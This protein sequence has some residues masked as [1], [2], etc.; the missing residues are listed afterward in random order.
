MKA[1]F[2]LILITCFVSCKYNKDLGR[3]VDSRDTTCIKELAKAEDDFAVNKLTYCHYIG[4]IIR[5]ELRSQKEMT[6]LLKKYNIDFTNK[7]SSCIVYEDQ[8]EYCYC[9]FMESKIKKRFGEKFIDS[10]LVEADELY[11]KNNIDSTFYYA[12]C[13]SRPMYP[14]DKDSSPDEQSDV[15]QKEIDAVL[16]YPVGYVKRP[17]YDVSAFTNVSFDVDKQGNAKITSFGFI[18][19][20]KANEK[21]IPYLEKEITSIIKKNEWQPATIRG[22]KVKS[23]MVL[24][25]YLK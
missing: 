14:G 19:D 3:N 24:R 13:D 1:V 4:N 9:E 11:L 5:H 6:Q 10:L 2:G 8:S 12:N 20:N 17:N 22:I 21:F 25:I 15:L 7:G 18:F 16:T 23:D